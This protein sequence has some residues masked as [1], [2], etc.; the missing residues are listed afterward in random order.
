MGPKGVA[1]NWEMIQHHNKEKK[2]KKEKQ[3]KE[4]C[5]ETKEEQW[6]GDTHTHTEPKGDVTERQEVNMKV[7]YSYNKVPDGLWTLW[8]AESLGGTRTQPRLH[9]S[10]KYDHNTYSEH[11]STAVCYY[12][13][14]Q[15][16]EARWQRKK[17]K[18][19]T[20]NEEI[21]C[22]L[23]CRYAKSWVSCQ[24]VNVEINFQRRKQPHYEF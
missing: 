5:W 24:C 21:T 13:G 8:H 12:C 15:L 9:H 4:S 10:E 3:R 14:S 23:W 2:K 11:S 18:L 17:K 20:R 1:Q 19:I 16:H 7:L 22:S 6:G